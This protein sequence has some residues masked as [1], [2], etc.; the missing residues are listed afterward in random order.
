[1]NICGLLMLRLPAAAASEVKVE[2]FKNAKGVFVEKFG[3]RFFTS[4]HGR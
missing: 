3:K 2:N 1:M 4:Q